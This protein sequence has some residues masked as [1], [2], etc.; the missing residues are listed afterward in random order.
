MTLLEVYPLKKTAI[1]ISNLCKNTF[2]TVLI[3]EDY[4][5]MEL[6][7]SIIKSMRCSTI[8]FA[9]AGKKEMKKF[10][11]IINSLTLVNL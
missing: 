7:K 10:P 9:T 3:E 5:D 11:I 6:L 2:L 4:S 8:K 1:P